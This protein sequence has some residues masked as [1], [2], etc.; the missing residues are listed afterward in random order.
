MAWNKAMAQRL[1]D[2]LAGESVVEKTM[3][4][5]LAFMVGG[6]M[7]AGLHKGGAF[8]RV[9]KPNEVAALALPG[10]AR[11]DMA[12]R[13]MPGMIVQTGGDDAVRGALMALAL[14]YIGS[15]QPK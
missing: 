13:A 3:F 6:H 8:F 5:G 10:T 9:G 2:D 15:L 11:M 7:V 1:R 14:G 4:G 12:G